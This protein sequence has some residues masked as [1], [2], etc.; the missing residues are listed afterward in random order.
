METWRRKIPRADKVLSQSD[1][2]C[3]NHFKKDDISTHWEV[4]GYDGK[5][6]KIERDKPVLKDDAIPCI[7]PNVPK[8]LSSNDNKKRK[9]PK[10][11]QVSPVP[12]KIRIYSERS[13]QWV[14][15]DPPAPSRSEENASMDVDD[16]GGD[17]S[18]DTPPMP[19]PDEDPMN[20]LKFPSSMWATCRS[21][22]SKIIYYH[23]LNVYRQVDKLVEY[24]PSDGSIS[25]FIRGGRVP[26]STEK[27]NNKNELEKV[28][29]T[30]HKFKLC[31]GAMPDKFSEGCS[32]YLEKP[33]MRKKRGPA[34]ERCDSCRSFRDNEKKKKKRF[35]ERQRRLA[36]LRKKNTEL[37]NENKK[38]TMK[39]MICYTLCAAISVVSFT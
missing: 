23:H 36:N 29:N 3:A 22:D 17:A 31:K 21:E 24:H 28:L 12:N 7:F 4:T 14:N 16:E 34:T 32:M 33:D 37:K 25:V 27:V 30:I 20:K 15:E 35:E 26:F 8:Y 39:V 10:E 11:R 19:S 13:S 6:V 1:S 5:V 9:A 2:V 18:N 38:L